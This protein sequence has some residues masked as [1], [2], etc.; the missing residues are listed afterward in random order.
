MKTIRFYL[1][2]TAWLIMILPAMLPTPAWAEEPA[3][4]NPTIDRTAL[5]GL[6]QQFVT[7]VGDGLKKADNFLGGLT[8]EDLRYQEYFKTIPDGDLMVLQAAL[9]SPSGK[10]V[11]QIKI[12]REVTGIKQGNDVMISLNDFISAAEFAITISLD[13]TKAEGWFIRQDQLFSLD[14]TNRKVTVKDKTLDILPEH[15]LAQDGDILV[16]G[17]TLATWFDLKFKID[18]QSQILNIAAKQ[19]WPMQERA[20]RARRM[21]TVNKTLKP[22]NPRREIPYH[23]ATVPNVAVTVKQGYIKNGDDAAVTTSSYNAQA[24]GDL[25]GFASKMTMTGNKEEKITRATLNLSHTSDNPDLLGPMKARFYEFNDVNTVSVPLTGSSSQGRGF[26]VTNKNPNITNNTATEVIGDGLPGW[27]VEMYRGDRLINT[28]TVGD[29]GQYRF[30]NVSLFLGEN[31]LKII[32]YGPQGEVREE[33]R[34]ISVS[35]D[36]TDGGGFYDVAVIQQ[37]VQTYAA[38]PPSGIDVGTPAFSGTYQKQITP[39]MSL[40][41]GTLIRQE[42]GKQYVYNS[43]GATNILGDIVLNSDGSVISDG[44]FTGILTGRRNIGQ[45]RFSVSA[46]YRSNGFATSHYTPASSVLPAV[47]SLTSNSSGPITLGF[48]DYKYQ[49]TYGGTSVI[50]QNE[51]GLR[52]IQ[53]DFSIGTNINDISISNAYQSSYVT[54]SPSPTSDGL[55]IDD[56]VSFRGRAFDMS[57]RSSMDF[58]VYPKRSL[59]KLGLEINREIYQDVN[60]NFSIDHTL[61]PGFTEGTLSTDFSTQMATI[62]PIL[63]YNTNKEASLLVSLRTGL[64]RDPYTN[65][66]SI[67]SQ[68]TTNNGSV[69]AFVFLDKDGDNSFTKGDEPLQDA[70]ILAVQL[71]DRALTNADG[72]AFLYNLSPKKVTDIIVE[73]GSAFENNWISGFEG[74][75]IR[76]RPGSVIRLQFPIHRGGELDGV[77]MV[78]LGDGELATVSDLRIDLYDSE[79]RRVMGDV[80]DS[81][82]YYLFER[83][84]P[85]TYYLLADNETSRR[86]HVI[87]PSLQQFSFGYEGTRIT[88]FNLMF[89]RGDTDVAFSIA[90][91]IS[92]FL[93]AN[94][95]LNVLEE[96]KQTILLNLGDYNSPLLMSLMWYK[97]KLMYGDAVSGGELVVRPVDTN[98]SRKTARNTLR[99]QINTSILDARK[100]CEVI[101]KDKLPCEVEFFP[102]GIGNQAAQR[103]PNRG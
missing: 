61:D 1:F 92:D 78:D 54:G 69:S 9:T 22:K 31:K 32:Q 94:P 68:N 50:S 13:G 36:K 57:W 55:K 14:V 33:E 6:A 97:I 40:E 87:R 58:T 89:K 53:S 84:P 99:V 79:G 47:V 20:E 93:D 72:E 44:T 67:L 96:Q 3:Q 5:M 38:N 7:K 16:K 4:K 101:N 29:D 86:K 24:R 2:L 60:A 73:E 80:T 49:G 76:A 43:F 41:A 70:S 28:T 102:K 71:N 34:V 74:V 77:A 90:P 25:L 19:P 100:R 42:N 39:T 37:S 12:D 103:L 91:D 21:K 98:P 88:G 17:E 95:V 11:K 48:G 65:E 52:N 82:G 10:K 66:F 75:S 18:I 64:A 81:D 51:N 83:I 26:H 59:R 30:T 56:S 46:Q 27:D 85:G 63:R 8:P 15:I 62:S 23:L 45:H 35:P